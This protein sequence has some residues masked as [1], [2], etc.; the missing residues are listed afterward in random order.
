MTEPYQVFLEQLRGCT[1]CASQLPLPPKPIVQ[2]QPEARILIAGQVPGRRAHDSGRPFA[3][4]SG[5]RLRNW[6]GIS[7]AEFYDPKIIAILPMGFCYPGKGPSG[8]LSPRPECAEHWR[9]RCLALLPHVDLT[10]L[11]GQYAQWWHLGYNGRTGLTETVK[12]WKSFWPD[13]V[14]LPH[15]SP[16]N[17]GW[18]KKNPWFEQEM[19]PELRANVSELMRTYVSNA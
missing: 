12:N 6:M 11:V 4:A 9:L 19:L 10:L 2:L 3:D 18:L 8:D 16:R 1:L 14:P 15:P 13:H 7:E 5:I 17:N